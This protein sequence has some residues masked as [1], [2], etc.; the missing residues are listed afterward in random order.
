MTDLRRDDLDSTPTTHV[1]RV[2]PD[3]A[4][5][6]LDVARTFAVEKIG[7]PPGP[8]HGTSYRWRNRALTVLA[9][10]TKARA[11][12]VAEQKETP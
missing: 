4:I 9:Y 8:R 11:V 5:V 6:M 10:W 12:V 7:G 2:T 3:K 1:W